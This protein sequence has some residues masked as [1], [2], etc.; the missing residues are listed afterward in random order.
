VK[1]LVVDALSFRRAD[2]HVADLLSDA[3]DAIYDILAANGHIDD[4]AIEAVQ[5]GLEAANARRRAAGTSPLER[6]RTFLHAPQGE[7]HG[8]AVAH[9]IAEMEIDPKQDRERHLLYEV[10]ERHPQALADGLLRRVREG[11]TLFYG[12]D[13]ILA[14]AGFALEDDALLG[15]ALEDTPRSDYRAEAAASVL[16]PTAVGRMIDAYFAAS[17]ALRLSDNGAHD[18]AASDRYSN[19][20]ARIA[21]TPGSSL[22]AAVQ[23]RAASTD[24]EDITQMAELLYRDTDGKDDRARPFSLEGL[25][26][27]GTLARDWGDRM[28][29]SGNANRRQTASIATLIS[30]APSTG[31]LPIIKRLLDDNLRRYRAFREESKANGWRQSEAL[32]EARWPHTHEYQ[33]AFMGIMAP[34]TDRLVSEYLADEHF[35]ELAAK[36]LAA[37]W[38]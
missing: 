27:I 24:N 22:I 19:L 26:A 17:N 14:S 36:V 5:R 32:N 12:A 15:I 13:D 35:G 7:D 6:L 21:H 38:S 20:R 3:S 25:A 30:H 31:L 18:R 8:A 2:R 1:A 4:I 16:G 10:R 23:A 34:E 33:R 28:L 9:I 37:H 29:V 11:R